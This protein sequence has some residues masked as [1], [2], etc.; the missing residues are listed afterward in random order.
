MCG[1]PASFL[2]LRGVLRIEIGSAGDPDPS[3]YRLRRTAQES[4]DLR[5]CPQ[6]AFPERQ[7]FSAQHADALRNLVCYA[8]CA[9]APK[10]RAKARSVSGCQMQ[11]VSSRVVCTH[12]RTR[13]PQL[14]AT[15]LRKHKEAPRDLKIRSRLHSTHAP[16]ITRTRTN[17]TADTPAPP[18]KPEPLTAPRPRPPQPT[19]NTL[20][21]TREQDPPTPTHTPNTQN[22]N[23][24]TSQEPTKPKLTQQPQRRELR[25]EPHS[26]EN[27]TTSNQPP[28]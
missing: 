13:T 4:Q 27:N 2:L 11:T 16:Q 1:E 8:A 21:E 24:G 3:P 5:A 14:Q 23:T 28:T 25:G 17:A 10:R 20:P 6:L 12:P 9:R 19:Q 18:H 26:N 22:P 7:A 15:K